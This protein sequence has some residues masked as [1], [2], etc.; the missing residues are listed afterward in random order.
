MGRVALISLTPACVSNAPFATTDFPTIIA[1]CLVISSAIYFD[2]SLSKL[3]EKVLAFVGAA[4]DLPRSHLALLSA[5]QFQ[6]PGVPHAPMNKSS[7]C[8]AS[9]FLTDHLHGSSVKKGRLRRR[10]EL[11]PAS[12][13]TGGLAEQHKWPYCQVS[14]TF[15]G[16][17]QVY[18]V[19]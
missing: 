19:S 16:G 14:F 1:S 9:P 3:V 2:K 10:S 15:A 5:S 4:A 6:D 7:G 17:I 18:C 11:R 13:H 8:S 12:H